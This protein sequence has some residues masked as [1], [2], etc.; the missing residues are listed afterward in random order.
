MPGDA[1]AL[2]TRT[3]FSV[4]VACYN[5]RPFVGD[6][7]RSLIGQHYPHELY[8][9]LFVDDGST[10]GSSA[11][12]AHF[13]KRHSGLRI[14]RIPNSGLEKAA[15]N[16]IRNA[17]HD[18][19]VRVD[20]D[21]ML[22]PEFLAVMDRAI[23]R[24]PDHDFFYS[25]N[26]YEYYSARE[27]HPKKLPEFDPEEIVERGDFFA[28]GTVYRKKDLF[29]AGLYQE[30]VKNC[31]LENYNLILR[32]LTEGKKGKAVAGAAFF[33]RR[34]KTN[35]S[36]VKRDAIIG[37]GRKLLRS[38]GREFKT[39][40]YHPYGLKLAS[41]GRPKV[42]AIIQARVG[43]TRLPA[44]IFMRLCGKP[45]I[46]H[47]VARLRKS[48]TLDEIILATTT[49]PGDDRLERW[50][51]RNKVPVFRGSETDV[52][53]RFYECAAKH[54]VDTIVR[55]TADDPFKDP[56]VLD[57]VVEMFRRWRL[58]FAYNNKPPSFPEGLDIEVLSFKALETAYRNA[59]D[60]FEREHVTPYLY[61]HPELF[62]QK[63]YVNRSNF[64]GFRWT[65][66]T[67]ADLRMAR[68]VYRSL[69]PKKKVFLMPDILGLLKQKPSLS[70]INAGV[71]RS[72]MYRRKK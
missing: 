40:R 57:A 72:D 35:M 21:D 6:C 58:D 9:I 25:R 2:K 24:F 51:R 30:A 4:I 54:E 13:Q 43:S 7:L 5:G 11:L 60:P 23:R 63:N 19:I 50:A 48:R 59:K 53:S 16:G 42:A 33:Y 66:D 64:S 1:R 46:H 39:N 26:Y 49:H 67:P 15:N 69:Y 44:K 34:H 14:L 68:E 45:F 29:K 27:N 52:L 18:R 61:R 41:A 10:D 55:I 12:A 65:V 32:F 36:T 8:E 37:Y 31:G 3:K 71:R 20:V 47:V 17:T 28:T 22:D 38:Y 70:A 56:R 62:R